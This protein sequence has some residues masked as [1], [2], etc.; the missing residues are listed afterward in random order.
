MLKVS[1]QPKGCICPSEGYTCQTY[2]STLLN[3][4]PTCNT[5][6]GDDLEFDV[7]MYGADIVERECGGFKVNYS[8]EHHRGQLPSVTS[9]LLVTNLSVNGTNLTCEGTFREMISNDKI[10]ICVVGKTVLIVSLRLNNHL[11]MCTN[12]GSATSPANVMVVWKLLSATV[13]FQPPVY[14]AECVDY[15]TVTA[16]SEE[17]NVTRTVTNDHLLN[18][19]TCLFPD[20]NTTDYNFTV[21]SV[22]IGLNGTVYHGD[23]SSTAVLVTISDEVTDGMNV[24]SQEPGI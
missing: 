17:R 16:I 8:S 3:W 19:F 18:T 7:I 9:T 14:G 15:Y 6:T 1:I 11:L 22:I 10:P 2:N 21:S 4:Y 24:T 23:T 5:A 20:L 13:S 12:I